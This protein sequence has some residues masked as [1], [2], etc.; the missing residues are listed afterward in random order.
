[1]RALLASAVTVCLFSHPAL[2]QSS[3]D[4]RIEMRDG[5][6]SGVYI[7]NGIVLT[8][9]HCVGGG[10]RVNVIFDDDGND[11]IRRQAVA[12]WISPTD[13]IAA[14]RLTKD[15]DVT[16]AVLSCEIPPIGENIAIIGNPLDQNFIYTWG[17]VA[18]TPRAFED[19]GDEIPIDAEIASGNS[20][21]PAFN[22]AGKVVGIVNEG[23]VAT[24]KHEIGRVN[25]M[26]SVIGACKKYG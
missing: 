14:Y 13:D 26:V 22:T 15:V 1:M 18:G 11:G 16:P 17:R 12:D 25:F 10:S 20:G 4:V 7:G 8:A 2:G 19:G 3:S 23:I 5:V 9:K 24:G 21:G 6:C